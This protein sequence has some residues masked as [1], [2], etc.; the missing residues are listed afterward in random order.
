MNICIG[1]EILFCTFMWKIQ[2]VTEV[3]FLARSLCRQR[4]MYRQMQLVYT[5]NNLTFASRVMI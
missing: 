3:F 4:P 1:G 2:N 5:V